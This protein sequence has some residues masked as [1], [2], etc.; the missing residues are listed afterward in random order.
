MSAV[1]PLVGNFARCIGWAEPE[2]LEG[3]PVRDQLATAANWLKQGISARVRATP[4]DRITDDLASYR[5]LLCQPSHFTV[6]RDVED[7]IRD[8]IGP[9]A[10]DD[11]LPPPGG[12]LTLDSRTSQ[13]PDMNTVCM[14]AY[15]L[16]S[17][18]RQDIRKVGGWQ[19]ARTARR[20]YALSIFLRS[21]EQLPTLNYTPATA[22]RW[23]SAWPSRIATKR[24]TW[25]LE[26]ALVSDDDGQTAA[27][28]LFMPSW[29][30]KATTGCRVYLAQGLGPQVCSFWDYIDWPHLLREH[31]DQLTVTDEMS[32]TSAPLR[33]VEDARAR[34][35]EARLY[36]TLWLAGFTRTGRPRF[37]LEA[38]D[39]EI[40]S[41]LPMDLA[42]QYTSLICDD[43]ERLELDTNVS[44]DHAGRW[45]GG[46]DTVRG[47]L[48]EAISTR[49]RSMSEV[50]TPRTRSME[51]SG[52]HHSDSHHW[53]FG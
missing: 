22:L 35:Y 50:F 46:L 18:L 11:L 15:A 4:L 32:P 48:S 10:A 1:I 51:L 43:C 33:I 5:R 40:D 36:V 26:H 52:D 23:G 14:S 31:P 24:E 19:A 9:D 38:W 16:S 47:L 28:S 41:S 7:A 2:H 29:L 42:D 44:H 49:G 27:L 20:L 3:L 34:G 13:D 6:T 25:F 8:D 12:R 37:Q 53:N 39:L 45:V 21:D 30:R 17:R